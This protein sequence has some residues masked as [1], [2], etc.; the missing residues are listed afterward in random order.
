MVLLHV[1]V[2]EEHSLKNYVLA[3]GDTQIVDMVNE[4]SEDDSRRL[5]KEYVDLAEKRGRHVLTRKIKSTVPGPA[6]VEELA[7]I[8]PHIVFMGSRGLSGL[9]KLFVGSVSQHVVENSACTVV[10]VK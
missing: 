1:V 8:K 5:M 2:E 9:K 6:I 7:R 4:E 10:I 3:G